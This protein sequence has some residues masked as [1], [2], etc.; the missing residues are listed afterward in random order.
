MGITGHMWDWW[1][2]WWDIDGTGG[3][4]GGNYRTYAEIVGVWGS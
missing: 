3:D 1:G 2:H 4:I